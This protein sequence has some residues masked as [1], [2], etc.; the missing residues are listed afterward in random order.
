MWESTLERVT[1]RTTLSQR[2][3]D[4]RGFLVVIWSIFFIPL[5]F[6]DIRYMVR[7]ASL[8]NNPTNDAVQSYVILMARLDQGPNVL[9]GGKMLTPAKRSELTRVA[10]VTSI[11][12]AILEVGS[13]IGALFVAD[14]VADQWPELLWLPLVL[15]GSM[16][17]YL[18]I[19][20]HLERKSLRSLAEQLNHD[21]GEQTPVI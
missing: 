18:S 21:E 11:R 10:N 6:S 17:F 9:F 12:D 5:R 15:G 19:D 4:L 8:G 3:D 13:W 2:G 14:K 16:W 7:T 1:Q 20:R